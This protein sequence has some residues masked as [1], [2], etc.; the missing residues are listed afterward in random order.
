M[1]RNLRLEADRMDALASICRTALSVDLFTKES[2]RRGQKPLPG[3]DI[4]SLFEEVQIKD[5]MFVTTS[6][7]VFREELVACLVESCLRLSLPP[8]KTNASREK[9]TAV[10]ALYGAGYQLSSWMQT[11]L[12][13]VEV[14]RPC[15]RWDCQGRTYAM[16]SYLKL[17][18]KLCCVYNTVGGGKKTKNVASPEQVLA[19]IRLAALQRELV[20]DLAEVRSAEN[21]VTTILAKM[22]F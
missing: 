2:V 19:E 13:V 22:Y 3:T 20:K 16:D 5:E 11:A 21:H 8:L 18:V 10:G 6:T 14:C 4:V 15:V 12:E 1:V 7:S 17:L 9:S